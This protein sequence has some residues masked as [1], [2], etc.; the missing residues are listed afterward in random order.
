MALLT[1]GGLMVDVGTKIGTNLFGLKLE[2]VPDGGGESD[3]GGGKWMRKSS[4][5]PRS[6]ERWASLFDP[7]QFS[8]ASEM[9]A[10][11]PLFKL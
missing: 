2:I 8:P 4:Y 1:P 10:D 7:F 5:Y 6:L 11:R 9:F 3:H